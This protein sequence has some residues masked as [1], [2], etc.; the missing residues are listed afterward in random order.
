MY[1]VRDFGDMIADRVRMA[2]YEA[3]LRRSVKP[4]SVVIDIGAG[5]GIF[6]LLACRLGARKVYAIDPNPAID[7]ARAVVKDNGFRDRVEFI[8]KMSTDVELPEQADVIVADVRGVLP[9]LGM[10]IGTMIDARSRLLRPGG[11]LIPKRDDLQ[12]S[13]VEAPLLYQPIVRPWEEFHDGFDVTAARHAATSE[14]N[15]DREN[16]ILPEQLLTPAQTWASIDY[17]TVAGP[18]V[19]GAVTLRAA[20]R[21]TAHGL[22]VWFDATLTD[23]DRFSV[24]P[25]TRCVYARVFFPWP[26]PVAVD[27]GASIQVDLR[28]TLAGDGYVFSWTSR[29]GERGETEFRQTNFFSHVSMDELLM[30][31]AHRPK[32]LAPRGLATLRA[33][34]RLSGGASLGEIAAELHKEFP[35][36]FPSQ[37]AAMA[38]VRALARKYA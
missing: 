5:T 4:G 33:L 10:S 22:V 36:Q 19:G 6:T 18:D 7:V 27:V 26:S 8:T 1:T 17:A 35:R 23:D 12:V 37:D 28:A 30:G 16:P 15:A 29:I 21:G 24:Q 20:R 34:E 3:A 2:A 11:V 14:W 38:A 25:G 32:K 9:M 13:V 31:A